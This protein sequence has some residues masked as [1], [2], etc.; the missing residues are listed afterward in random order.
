MRFLVGILIFAFHIQTHAQNVF[1]SLVFDNSFVYNNGIYTSLEELKYNSPSY[2]DCVLDLDKNQETINFE[3]LYFINSRNT[4]LKYE[5]ALYAI[6]DD[7][8]L[9]IFY[10][11]FFCQESNLP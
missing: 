10:K 8:H 11:F 4:R 6:V 3:K 1:D 9:S 7:G 5:S 2:P